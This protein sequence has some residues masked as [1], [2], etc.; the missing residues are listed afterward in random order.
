MWS[1]PINLGYPINTP[2][3][4]I[5]FKMDE[6]NKHAYYSSVRDNG[7]GGKDLY[8]VIFLGEEKELKLSTEDIFLAWNYKLIEDMFYHEP[9]EIKVDTALFMIGLVTDAKTG[10][11]IQMAKIELIDL[12]LSQVVATGLT[13]AA[14]T[15][16]IKIPKKKDFGVEVTAKDYL[17]FVEMVYLSQKQVVDSKVQANFQLDKIDV[18]ATMVLNNIFFETN[19]AT[20]K[21]ESTTE[22]E[23]LASLLIENP[24]IRLEISGHTDNVGSYRANQKLSESRAKSVVEYL[25]SKGV[26]SS[27][28]EY[29]GYSFNQPIAD[30]N[31]A[32]GRSQNRRVEFKVLSK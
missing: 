18:G 27:R 22:L 13:D 3:D 6:H 10:D 25:V 31:T 5:F 26:G 12:D 32:E 23:R 7:F 15:Y 1:N 19:K 28:L 2:N 16:K 24:T 29:K 4:D 21:P 8:K 9:S 11:S 20:I 14:G 30:N 17:Y